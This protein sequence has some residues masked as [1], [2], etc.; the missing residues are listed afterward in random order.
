MITRLILV[1]TKPETT[2]EQIQGLVQA[3]RALGNIPGVVS[4]TAGENILDRFKDRYNV[5]AVVTFQDQAALDAYG[6]HELHQ[7]LIKEHMSVVREDA[8][9]LDFIP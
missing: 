1:K 3:L 7:A 6:P 5:M 8:A 2:P 9:L 4:A